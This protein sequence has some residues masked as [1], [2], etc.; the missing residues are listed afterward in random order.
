[1]PRFVLYTETDRSRAI[2]LLKAVDLKKPN[3][4]ELKRQRKSRTVSQNKLYWMWLACISDETGDTSDSLHNYYMYNFLPAT[5]SV[6]FGIKF[7]TTK[8]T[9]ELDTKEFTTYLERIRQHAAEWNVFLPLP[10]ER[11]FE[12]FYTKYQGYIG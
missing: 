6:V 10:E 12:E 4:F 1:M 7:E 9:T 8:R 2:E 5:E 3:V 11:G